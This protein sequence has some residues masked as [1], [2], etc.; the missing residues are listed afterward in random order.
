MMSSTMSAER[1]RRRSSG[2]KIVPFPRRDSRQV[3]AIENEAGSGDD[4]EAPASSNKEVIKPLRRR[5]SSKFRTREVWPNWITMMCYY[6]RRALV[7]RSNTSTLS[8]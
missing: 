6:L 1:H 5:L 4:V 3:E 2:P 8:M 7:L